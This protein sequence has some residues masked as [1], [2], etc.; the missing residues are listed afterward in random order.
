ML[1]VAVPGVVVMLVEVAQD[2][3]VPA[4]VRVHVPEPKLMALTPDPDELKVPVVRLYAPAVS[5]PAVSVTVRVEPTVRASASCHV[6]PTPL[7]VTAESIVL[8]TVVMVLI[9]DVAAKRNVVPTL[10]VMPVENVRSPYIVL[11]S[12]RPRVPLN[13][14]KFRLRDGPKILTVSVP[15]VT[16]RDVELASDTAPKYTPLVPTLPE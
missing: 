7:K 3:A 6:P 16:F 15:A 4:A 10:R 11:V 2:H 14:V 12:V 8:P 5:V 13:P 9:P 1:I